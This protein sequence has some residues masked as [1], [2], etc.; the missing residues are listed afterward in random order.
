M[1]RTTKINVLAYASRPEMDINYFG[2]IVEY[3]GKRYFVSLSEEV[4]EF[5][6]IVKE[7]GKVSDMENLEDRRCGMNDKYISIIT[8][9]GCHYTCPYCIVK[10]NNLD[11]PRTTING[12]DSLWL[13]IVRNQCNWVSLS[14]G[15]D[16]LWHYSEH[17]DWYDKFFEIAE[18]LNI[19]LHTSLPNVAGAPYDAFDRVVY[20]L[21]SLE[22]LY[23]IKRQNCAIVRVVFV[24]TEN[25]T[26]DLIN[27]IAVFCANSDDIDELSFRQMVDNR[28]QETYYCYEYLKAGH[29]KLWWYIEQNDYNLYYCQNKVYTEYKN[30]GR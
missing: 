14:G 10:N 29:K 17:K 22:Q 8:N 19:E 26:E 4:V 18:D 16:P 30:I 5:R 21:H 12:L 11:I 9:F 1:N 13:E 25:F 7:S 2:D 23:S 6:G 3:Q 24:V 15:G 27:R 20:H 28:Y